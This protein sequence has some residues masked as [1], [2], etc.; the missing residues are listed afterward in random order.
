MPVLWSDGFESGDFTGWNGGSFGVSPTVQSTIK[1]SGNYAFEANTADDDFCLETLPSSYAHLF[2]RAYIRVDAF[3]NNDWDLLLTITDSGYVNM[4]R[5]GIAA[6]AG[7]TVKYWGFVVNGNYYTSV[8]TILADTWYCME[9][10]WNTDGSCNMWI[11]SNLIFAKV[12]ET[13][14]NNAQR[15][16]A[17]SV[18]GPA[19]AGI[20]NYIDDAVLD[21]SQ[22]GPMAP[23]VPYQGTVLTCLWKP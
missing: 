8:A 23:E 15:V 16:Q 6:N 2:Y 4:V 5:G 11:D 1:H 13:L 20:T 12:G 3:P 18:Y 7:M 21:I 22:I 14:T 19:P 10:D 17:G 9:I